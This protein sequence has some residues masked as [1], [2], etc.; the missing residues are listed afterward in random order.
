MD[1]R[2]ESIE[3]S[4]KKVEKEITDIK[5]YLR[6]GVEEDHRRLKSRVEAL[7]KKVM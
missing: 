5:K 7:E 4:V 3:K 2:L 6:V 1:I